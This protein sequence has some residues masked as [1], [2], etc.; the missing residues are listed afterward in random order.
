MSS[1]CQDLER[2]EKGSEWNLRAMELVDAESIEIQLYEGLEQNLDGG[3]RSTKEYLGLK[4]KMI[5]NGTN[6][7]LVLRSFC[8]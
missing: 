8:L 3:G 5:C 1:N 4:R 2:S 7:A 6:C